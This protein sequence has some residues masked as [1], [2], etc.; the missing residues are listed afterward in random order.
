MITKGY[1]ENR[2]FIAKNPFFRIS[3]PILEYL[4][5]NQKDKLASIAINQRFEKNKDLC[6]E[7]ELAAS[8]YILKSG[9]LNKYKQGDFS[10][11]I[12]KGESFEEY[13]SLT[14]GGMRRFTI[15][16]AED[17]E[18]VALGIEDIENALGRSLPLIILRNEA[19]KAL[20]SSPV[21]ERLSE[22]Y[23]ERAIDCFKL[24]AVK[25]G[26]LLTRKDDLCKSCIFFVAEGQYYISESSKR[27]K[28]YGGSSL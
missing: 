15:K 25:A 19:L 7:G 18:V 22:E 4:T 11:T 17:V 21:F 24:K 5:E 28:I 23:V 14:K 6:K 12:L 8:M 20:K 26:D 2:A 1:K 16:A 13:A 9:K 3:L 10:G 27:S